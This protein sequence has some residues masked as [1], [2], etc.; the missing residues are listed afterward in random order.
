M[1]Q[2]FT[3]VIPFKPSNELKHDIEQGFKLLTIRYNTELKKLKKRYDYLI[4]TQEYEIAKRE[5]REKTFWE[6]NKFTKYDFYEFFF[7]INS[8]K[9][10]EKP[11]RSIYD[12]TIVS[13]TMLR[14]LGDHL[15]SSFE[16]LLYQN[17]KDVHPKKISSMTFRG[18]VQIRYN[19]H[20]QSF[21][22]THRGRRNIISQKLDIK[23]D[24]E[25][26]AFANTMRQVTIK[27]QIIRGKEKY[28]FHIC[29]R[30]TPYNKGRELGTNSVGIDPSMLKMFACYSNGE[31]LEHSLIDKIDEKSGEICDSKYNSDNYEK[32]EKQVGVLQTQINKQRRIKNPQFFDENGKINE[33]AL[34]KAKLEHPNSSPWEDSK[35]T[36]RRK[37]KLAQIKRNLALHRKECHFRLANYILSKANTIKVEN[38]SYKSFQARAKETTYNAN[39][40][41]RSKKRFGKSIQKGAPSAFI[42]I[43]KNKAASWGDRVS[44]NEVGASEACTQFDHTNDEFTKHELKERVVELSNGDRVHRDFHA[45]MNILFFKNTVT[46][47]KK[48]IQKDS[49]HFDIEGMREFYNQHRENMIT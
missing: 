47:S 46:K 15:L 28:F 11:K 5:K 6:K 30:G 27:K 33:E 42:T 22:F 12:N 43:L 16:K 20:A 48:R 8:F 14:A 40:R 35:T 39:G 31:M 32:L 4:K 21:E 17:G 49:D 10:T 37:N 19:S 3:L 45:A 44:F 25:L 34:N 2:E 38:N 9:R 41:P 18:L 23:T 24:Y 26:H 29:F 13:S 1:A 7:R 36:I